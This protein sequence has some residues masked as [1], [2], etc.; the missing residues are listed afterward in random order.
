V[1]GVQVWGGA[2][3]GGADE[4]QDEPF[5]G[6]AKGLEGV[7]EDEADEV[8]VGVDFEDVGSVSYTHLTLPTKA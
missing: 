8:G 7:D 2:E 5:E 1:S 3:E 6:V 4:F